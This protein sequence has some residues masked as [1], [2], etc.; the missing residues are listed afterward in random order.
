MMNNA[1]HAT[2]LYQSKNQLIVKYCYDW[3]KFSINSMKITS[4]RITNNGKHV[5]VHITYQIP[6]L[7]DIGSPMYF[8]AIIPGNT[9]KTKSCVYSFNTSEKIP[10]ILPFKYI[11][12]LV[13]E[14][15][16]VSGGNWSSTAVN[17]INLAEKCNETNKPLRE[18]I[19]D[20]IL[21]VMRDDAVMKKRTQFEIE[22]AKTAIKSWVSHGLEQGMSY[23][24]IDEIIKECVVKSVISL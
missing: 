2:E 15:K 21:N 5:H 11:Y 1:L 10:D 3:L 9:K 19:I 13:S 7:S 24:E 16:S 4:A 17:V 23:E 20:V 18:E 14:M 6:S 12:D 22:K 8:G